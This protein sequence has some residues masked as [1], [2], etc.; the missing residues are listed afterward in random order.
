M[1]RDNRE[2]LA[3]FAGEP[4][5]V[6]RLALNRDQVERYR[7]PPNPAKETDSRFAVYAEQF[8]PKSWELDALDP[9]VIADLIRAELD[10]LIDAE[11]WQAAEAKERSN[12]GLLEH[13]SRNWPMVENFLNR[14]TRGE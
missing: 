14:E 5:E 2:R 4:I 8:G 1:T 3:M 10:S 6:R 9:T 11:R 12:R 7:L 13:A